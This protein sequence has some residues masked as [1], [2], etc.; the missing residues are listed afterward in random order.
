MANVL[1]KVRPFEES[2]RRVMNNR[3]DEQKQVSAESWT[4]M[5][6]EEW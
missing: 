6:A 4:E 2:G 3:L 5:A 1:R